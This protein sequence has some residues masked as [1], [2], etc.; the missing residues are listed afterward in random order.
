MPLKHIGSHQNKDF[1]ML[2]PNIYAFNR[3]VKQK[4][5]FL[6]REFDCQR[7]EEIDEFAA[8]ITYKTKTNS[9][10]L[11]YGVFV[12]EIDL[13][14]S[15]GDMEDSAVHRFS[16][17]EICN[18]LNT[19][20]KQNNFIIFKYDDLQ[21]YINDLAEFIKEK[22]SLLFSCDAHLKLSLIQNRKNFIACNKLEDDLRY[23]R[24]NMS[25]LW[26]QK[27]YADIVKLLSGYEK[28]LSL[29][30]LKKYHYC[31]KKAVMGE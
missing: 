13:R 23:I 12:H 3:L 31:I 30:E 11:C 14:F 8:F 10:M 28:Y 25:I 5:E 17:Q 7:I 19:T 1:N 26:D 18:A 27:K 22:A 9:L 4:F 24:A 2:K 15:F 16:V 20:C 29:A 6:E 21:K